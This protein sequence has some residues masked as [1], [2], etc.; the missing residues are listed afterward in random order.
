MGLRRILVRNSPRGDQV[1]AEG[2]SHARRPLTVA[3]AI[4]H[5]QCTAGDASA[6]TKRPAVDQ[7][8]LI[9]TTW[10]PI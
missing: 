4:A 8:S 2:K 5:G 7:D 10:R 6:G 1:T 3:S 9:S